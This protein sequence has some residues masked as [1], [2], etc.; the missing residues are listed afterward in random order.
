MYNK[1]ELKSISKHELI[2]KIKQAEEKKQKTGNS[3]EKLLIEY[4]EL[5][6]YYMALGQ[7][8]YEEA[9]SNQ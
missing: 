6:Y 8:Q 2:E 1:E 5:N 9:A 3:A 7:K 4:H